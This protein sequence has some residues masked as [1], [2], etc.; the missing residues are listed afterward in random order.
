LDDL[1]K[2]VGGDIM[3]RIYGPLENDAEFVRIR[4]SPLSPMPP[5]TLLFHPLYIGAM[6]L[7]GMWAERIS[8][9][10]KQSKSILWISE[11]R[12]KKN[13]PQAKELLDRHCGHPIWRKLQEFMQDKGIA[14]PDVVEF[15]MDGR[16]EFSVAFLPTAYL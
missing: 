13:T 7:G 15:Y 4:K 6:A 3:T 14:Y 5:S 8:D 11:A 1:H 10:T 2:E 9:A 16:I 12:W